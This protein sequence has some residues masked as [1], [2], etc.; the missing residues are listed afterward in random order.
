MLLWIFWSNFSLAYYIVH[1]VNQLAN[2]NFHFRRSDSKR[3]LSSIKKQGK[4]QKLKKAKS[5]QTR[6]QKIKGEETTIL[7]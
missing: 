4:N 6:Q 5:K 3:C 7:N 2:D 1:T